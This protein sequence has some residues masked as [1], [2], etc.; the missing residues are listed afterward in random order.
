[1]TT[2][3]KWWNKTV[4]EEED[5]DMGEEQENDREQREKNGG[6]PTEHKKQHCNDD[7]NTQQFFPMTLQFKIASETKEEANNKHQAILRAITIHTKHCEIYST[8]GERTSLKPNSLEEFTY[9]K[10][11]NQRQNFHTTI[12]KM[13]L[14]IEYHAIKKNKEILHRLQ[15]TNCQLQLHEWKT[16]EW[17]VIKVGFISG[18]SPKHQSKETVQQKLRL[19]NPITTKYKLHATTLKL[20]FNDQEY[21]TLAYEIHC[22]RNS[23]NAVCEYIAQACKALDQTFIKYQ[24]KHSNQQTYN[25]GIKKQIKFIDSIRTIPVF[26]IHPM[27]MDLIYNDLIQEVNILD[28]NNTNKTTTHG[29]WNIYVTMENFE[30]QTKWFQH[31]I[32]ELYNNKCS[33]VLNK[34]PKDYVPAVRFKSTV[35]FQSTADP[36]LSD[37]EES[38]R[39]FSNTPIGSKSWASVV[40]GSTHKPNQTISTITLTN[41]LSIQ[42]TKLSQSIEKICDRLDALEQRMNQEHPSKEHHKTQPSKET[43]TPPINQPA[44]SDSIAKL[45]RLGDL[46]SRL[47]E[48][49]NCI[50]SRKLQLTHETTRPNKRQDL[51]Q[52]P[53]KN[54]THPYSNT[55]S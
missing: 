38:V 47:E 46:I 54:R 32:H 48:R 29:R 39:H 2:L 18:C 12:H 44:P 22:I 52:S 41:D 7:D 53:T 26:G 8:N 43:S 24:W 23:Y 30:S 4:V 34:I 42:M 33:T 28:I 45:D 14:D 50:K 3:D 13:I 19:I 17:D 27:A 36:L 51:R 6:K 21:C 55:C 5:V 9:H 37:A 16:E 25:N 40:S 10:N 49:T 31:N 20:T 15:Q 11:K 35:I 1:M